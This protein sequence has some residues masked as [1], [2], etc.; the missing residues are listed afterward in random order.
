MAITAG[1]L[2]LL[3]AALSVY[4]VVCLLNLDKVTGSIVNDSLPAVVSAGKIK[5]SLAE[6]WI[7]LQRLLAA[8]TPSERQ[9]IKAEMVATSQAITEA[10]KRYE[11]LACVSADRPGFEAFSEKREAYRA[12]REQFIKQLET[13]PEAARKLL[14]TRVAP[15]YQ[16]Y[17]GAADAILEHNQRNSDTRGSALAASVRRDAFLI[18]AAAATG[19]LL[20]AGASVM[21]VRSANRTLRTVSAVLNEGASQVSCASGQVASASQA[22]AAGAG[23]AASLEEISSSLEEMAS[24]TQRNAESAQSAKALANQT[25]EA[26]EL[27]SGNIA[28]MIAAIDTIRSS[29]AATARILKTI[30]DISFQTNLLAL[31][32]SVEAARAGEA[33]TGFAVVAD[34]VRGLAQRSARAAAETASQIEGSIASTEEA[35]RICARAAE[36]LRDIVAKARQVDAIVEEVASASKEQNLGIQQV[37][38]ALAQM[39]QVTQSSASSSEGSAQAAA[40]LNAQAAALKDAT[41]QLLQLAGS[42]PPPSRP[43]SGPR[44]GAEGMSQAA[45]PSLRRLGVGQRPSAGGHPSIHLTVTNPPKKHKVHFS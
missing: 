29:G 27:G 36:G 33:G 21:S 26:A 38:A 43:S 32:A 1:F 22:L 8:T 2:C 40:Q 14:A 41:D 12:I 18:V 45:G 10:F 28:G 17:S 15:A 20:A 7:R 13:D 30:D 5:I 11:G 9:Q 31:N 25:R 42:A 44:G 39:D 34:E 6:N 3:I 4:A 23:Q 37:N 19:L 16:A 35:A 24:M